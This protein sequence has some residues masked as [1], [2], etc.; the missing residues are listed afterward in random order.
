M[1]SLHLTRKSSLLSRSGRD[2]VVG[3]VAEGD[4]TDAGVGHQPL[5]RADEVVEALLQ[6]VDDELHAAGGV[7]DQGNVEPLLA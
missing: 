7:D 1:R 6:V 2:V 4:G 3:A 5:H